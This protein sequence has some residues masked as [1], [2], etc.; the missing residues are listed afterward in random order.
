M[1]QRPDSARWP[2]AAVTNRPERA[3]TD[4]GDHVTVGDRCS[5]HGV[6][7]TRHGLDGHRVRVA[8]GVG[9]CVEL[10][11]VGHEARGRPAAAC[12]GAEPVCRP[13]RMWPKAMY[14]QF[15][16]SP[17]WQAGH[18][19]IDPAGGAAEYR[20]QHDPAAGGQ[21]GT[22]GSRGVF[23]QRADHLVSRDEGK[24]D[25]VLEIARAA[26]VQ[27]GQVG[28]ADPRQDRID[29]DPV[30]GRQ[31]PARRAR[32]GA[33]GRRRRPFPIRRTTRRVPRRSG[34][35]SAR[36]GG[37]SSAHHRLGL[38]HVEGP[39]RE[40]AVR[41]TLGLGPVLHVPAPSPGDGRES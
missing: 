21:H 14:P 19:G 5:Q 20:L 11:G 25:D 32:A 40:R 39:E 30:R 10:A 9:H 24:R 36:T 28:P 29:V 23:G 17:A 37:C 18:M 27:G 4:D 33:A 31:S 35:A 38:P 12:V 7:G 13:G 34:A 22:L 6:H 26:S 1:A 2:R 16:T 15:P 3:R 8:Q 41:T